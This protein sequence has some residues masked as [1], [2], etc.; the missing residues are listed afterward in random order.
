MRNKEKRAIFSFSF[1]SCYT[2]LLLVVGRNYRTFVLF[3]LYKKIRLVY[4]FKIFPIITL[5]VGE[6]EA[7]GADR[8]GNHRR[9]RL[10]E[11]VANLLRHS[12]HSRYH[13]CRDRSHC[14]DLDLSLSV[15]R[16]INLE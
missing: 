14:S 9:N 5:V 8:L 10:G 11:A 1:K 15:I 16:E 2:C 12:F 4:C 7:S 3:F 13:Y 6:V